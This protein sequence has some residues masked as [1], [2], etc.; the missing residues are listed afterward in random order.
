MN[1]VLDGLRRDWPA[2]VAAGVVS[3]LLV[4]VIRAWVTR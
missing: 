2:L 1:R 3:S 4:A